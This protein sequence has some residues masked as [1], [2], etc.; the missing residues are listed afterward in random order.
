MDTTNIVLYNNFK[1]TYWLFYFYFFVF[2]E[3]LIVCLVHKL[4]S[5]SLKIR[6]FILLEL[7]RDNF[8]EFV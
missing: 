5:V 6:N 4:R 1:C 8:S 3:T 7:L 2:G